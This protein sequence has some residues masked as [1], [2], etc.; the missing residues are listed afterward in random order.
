MSAAQAAALAKKAGEAFGNRLG[1]HAKAVM[2]QVSRGMES[3]RGGYS[4]MM[5]ANKQ[6]VKDTSYEGLSRLTK[7]FYYTRWA[8]LPVRYAE[9]RKQLME[10]QAHARNYETWTLRDAGMGALAAGELLAFFTAGEIVGR[11]SLFGYSV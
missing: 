6:Y 11:G 3:V 5:A 8:S 4:G 10:L 7:E 9:A 2:E 1:P